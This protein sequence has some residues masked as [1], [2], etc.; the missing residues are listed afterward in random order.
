[1]VE[2]RPAADRAARPLSIVI[3]AYNEESRLPRT[4]ERIGAFLARGGYDAE[5]LVVDDGSRDRTSERSRVVAA[6][7]PYVKIIRY[8]T[9]HGK[10]FAVRSGVLAATREA[11]LF[12]DADLSTPIEEIERFWEPYDRGADVVIGSRRRSESRIMVRQ[13]LHR[14]VIGRA[15]S[16]VVSLLGVRGIPD[17]QCGF[18]LFRASRTRRIFE[19]LKTPGFAFDVELLIG[20]RARGLRIAEVPV[21]WI[22][23]PESHVRPVVDSSRMLVELLR[24]RGLG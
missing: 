9:N 10:G 17:T 3:P 8:P 23:S 14:R 12:T 7:L 20:A 4:L 24:M 19:A 16:V 21:T 5:V 18:K 6:E 15:W 11:V 2:P 1:M 22:D 13:P